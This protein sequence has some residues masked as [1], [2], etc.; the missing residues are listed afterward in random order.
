MAN[1]RDIKRIKEI[2]VFFP[3]YNEEAN[4]TSTVTKAINVLDKVAKEW[5]ILMVNDGSSDNTL[6]I[7]RKL[8]KED[9][10]LKVINHRQNKGYGEALK[11]GF[12]NAKHSW[13]AT[14]DGDG[15]FDFSE[16]TKLWEKTDKAQV[17][18]GFRI[19]RRDPLI[20]IIFGWGWTALANFLLGINVRDVD[21]SFKLVRKEVIEKIPHLESTRGGMIS[22]EL[23]AKAKKEGFIIDQV[24]VHH[25]P[26][27]VGHQTGA[28]IKVIIKSFVDLLGLWKNLRKK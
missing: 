15:Q 14:I 11:S 3:F 26:R 17:V 6:K 25:Y 28:D 27:K 24:G 13:I 19:E 16:I 10:R 20:R 8:A 12:Y 1:K 22:P 5:E 9:N 2:S 18:I 4:I 21:C 7:A 23:L